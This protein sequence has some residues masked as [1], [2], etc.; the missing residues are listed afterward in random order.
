MIAQIDIPLMYFM[1]NEIP[2][3]YRGRV[4]SIGL[5]LGKIMQPIALA[6]S[7]LL[8]NFIPAY[9]LPI[10][11]DCIFTLNKILANK[12]NLEIHSKDYSV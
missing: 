2:E 4:L 5:S 11:G 6:I 7:G 1:Q 8:L 10:A 3:E 12:F 9:T